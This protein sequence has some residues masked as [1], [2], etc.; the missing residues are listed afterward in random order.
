MLLGA[1]ASIV[2]G[3]WAPLSYNVAK[4]SSH[5]NDSMQTSILNSASEANSIARVALAT[6]SAQAKAIKDSQSILQVVGQLALADYCASHTV[7]AYFYHA[8]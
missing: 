6:A 8:S 1:A 5:S 7:G 3:I 4:T 2:F